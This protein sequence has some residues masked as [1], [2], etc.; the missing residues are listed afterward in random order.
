MRLR[1]D[2]RDR[3]R[4]WYVP[5]INNLRTKRFE[6][7]QAL[8]KIKARHDQKVGGILPVDLEDLTASERIHQLQEELKQ[9]KERFIR[10]AEDRDRALLKKREVDEVQRN[11]DTNDDDES[12]IGA[13]LNETVASQ[14]TGQHNGESSPARLGTSAA[15]GIRLGAQQVGGRPPSLPRGTAAASRGAARGPH[16]VAS[17]PPPMP[18]GGAC[19][20]AGGARGVAGGARGGRGARGGPGRGGPGR[21]GPGRGGPGRGGPG[22]GGI[23][24]RLMPTKPEVKPRVKM[25][26]LHWDR[27]LLGSEES[28]NARIAELEKEALMKKEAKGKVH[29]VKTSATAVPSIW[30][31]TSEPSL[32]LDLLDA[33]LDLSKK[34]KKPKSSDDAGAGGGTNKAAKKG[35]KKKNSTRKLRVVDPGRAQTVAI[36]LSKLPE[37]PV[38]V[39]S[40]DKLDDSKLSKANIDALIKLYPTA[41]EL[42]AIADLKKARFALVA[43]GGIVSE[44]GVGTGKVEWDRP[45]RLFMALGKIPS[46]TLR[47]TCWSF[48]RGFDEM[49]EDI[50]PQVGVL[51]R[52]CEE[53]RNSSQLRVVS[54]PFDFASFVFCRQQEFYRDGT[55]T[56]SHTPV[57]QPQL[58]GTVLAIG[59]YMNGGTR[60]GRADGFKVEALE[61]LYTTKIS[62]VGSAEERLEGG[63]EENGNDAPLK[64]TNTLIDLVAHQACV[65]F[66]NMASSAD[67]AETKKEQHKGDAVAQSVT[68]SGVEMLQSILKTELG[69]LEQATKVSM[70]DVK[71][72]VQRLL[73]HVQKLNGHYARVVETTNQPNDPFN[74]KISDFLAEASKIA[75]SLSAESKYMDQEYCFTVR[76][77]TGHDRK[78]S[79]ATASEAFFGIVLKFVD[80]VVKAAPVVRKKKQEA[81]QLTRA[82]GS[83]VDITGDA[84]TSEGL[85]EIKEGRY[86]RSKRLAAEKQKRGGKVGGMGMKKVM[87]GI[88]LGVHLKKT[89]GPQK[90]EK[91]R[92]SGLMAQLMNARR[93]YIV[94]ET[95]TAHTHSRGS[96]HSRNRSKAQH[97]FGYS[98]DEWDVDDD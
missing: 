21:G 95:P 62:N 47:L 8:E 25:R 76:Y 71:S 53:I 61:R 6:Q 54:S 66:S 65:V 87:E 35:T 79:E 55:L 84:K 17:R 74:T 11:N 50:K 96:S 97:Q 60:R 81:R 26:A 22:R 23:R 20:G 9:L 64:L 44:Q 59:N 30:L 57:F 18:R 37:I 51:L 89:Q 67:T 39:D 7:Q 58:M 27:I 77:F 48:E 4:D 70:N 68:E 83:A 73:S 92:P 85:E 43:K 31:Q 28:K 33:V 10:V 90:K 52:C 75:Q 63:G 46:C 16:G 91:A 5:G 80:S 15:R 41:D 42:K 13:A 34:N 3:D 36:T 1:L 40:I 32:N 19:G 38:I 2:A 45:E 98:D 29:P 49:L 69:S 12:A 14:K 86:A 88:K 78:K 93:M 94:P 72:Q 82:D 56:H 24:G